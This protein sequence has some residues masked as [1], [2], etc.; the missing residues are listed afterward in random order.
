MCHAMHVGSQ[1]ASHFSLFSTPPSLRAQ[2][3]SRYVA[4]PFHV[5]NNEVVVVVVVV[6]VIIIIINCYNYYYHYYYY[7]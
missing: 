6:V 7:Y 4:K 1:Y 5:D 3:V 2:S